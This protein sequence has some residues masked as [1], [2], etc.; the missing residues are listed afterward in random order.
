MTESSSGVHRS[1]PIRR[2]TV[3]GVVVAE[4]SCDREE[5]LYGVVDAAHIENV[6]RSW[7]FLRDRRIDAY[8]G[9]TRRFIDKKE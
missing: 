6:R 2:A 8:E 1:L 3:D 7:P 4:A 5:T 9:I